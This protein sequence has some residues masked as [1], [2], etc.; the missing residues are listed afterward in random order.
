MKQISSITNQE[1][2]MMQDDLSFKSTEMQKSQTTARNLTSGENSSQDFLFC[3]VLFLFFLFLI[4]NW[5]LKNSSSFFFE[6]FWKSYKEGSNWWV[7]VTPSLAIWEFHMTSPRSLLVWHWHILIHLTVLIE[8]RPF[9]AYEGFT[10]H[11]VYACVVLASCST[12]S[13]HSQAMVCKFSSF[14]VVQSG[15]QNLEFSFGFWS[16]VF[17]QGKDI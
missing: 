17:L 13:L 1:L 15:M 14:T 7:P 5:N 6:F 10:Y 16:L 11:F 4:T 12:T 9:L 2:K 8:Y 3:F